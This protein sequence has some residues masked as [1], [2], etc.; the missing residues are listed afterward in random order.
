MLN[1]K[2]I[3]KTRNSLLDYAEKRREVIKIAGDA[4]QHAKKSIFA[5][6]R[7]DKASAEQKLKTCLDLLSGLIKKH[8]ACDKIFEEGSFKSAIEEYV[9]A[10]LFFDV[11]SGNEINEI[12]E[13]EINPEAYISGLCDVPG[14][15]Y[16]YAI[17]SATKRDF[18]TT[19]KCHEI[20]EEIVGEL[21]DM[22]LTG[23][24]RTKFD[25]AKQALHKLEQVVYEISFSDK[26]CSCKK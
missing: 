12:K 17:H 8:K 3:Q 11:I 15:L 10:R 21:L 16:R 25:Q 18:K 6:Q 19:K 26:L 22:D 23:Y 4:Q 9:E 2:Y 14:E 5:L 20:A 7:E 24:N 1:K 13:I